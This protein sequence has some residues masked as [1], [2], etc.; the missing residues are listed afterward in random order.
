MSGVS[1]GLPGDI[2]TNNQGIKERLRVDPGQTGF[3]LG[4]M[5]RSF[6]EQVIP[7]AGPS[8]QFRFT[9][10]VNFILWSQTLTL[11]QGAI[12][13]EVFTAPATVTGT[14]TALPVLGV[15][16]MTEIPQPPY[17]PVCTIETGGDFTGGT[18]LDEMII[19]CGNN[20]GNQSS[21]NTGGEVTERG[22]P[23][24]SVFYGRFSTLTGGVAPLDAAQLL[25]T[26]TWEERP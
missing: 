22:L 15:N 11:T 4:R 13:F 8:V 26:L 6:T 1:I 23:A 14:W 20:Q 21:S 16:R 19:K 17:V 12:R 5:F 2:Y 18:R 25:Y 9:A 3:F 24:G 10:P 7:V